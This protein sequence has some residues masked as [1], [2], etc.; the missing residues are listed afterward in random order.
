[1][2]LCLRTTPQ[3]RILQPVSAPEHFIAAD[4]IGRAEDAEF[5][6]TGGFG[7]VAL[8]GR[9]GGG[10]GQRRIHIFLPS[11]DRIDAGTGAWPGSSPPTNQA[12]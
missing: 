7:G 3:Q 11:R 4:K 8:T 1:M 12:S 6:G 9:F 2:V 10:Q 5:A